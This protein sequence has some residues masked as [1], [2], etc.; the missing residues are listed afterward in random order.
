MHA[1]LGGTGGRLMTEDHE[2]EQ[3]ATL[4]DQSLQ[5]ARISVRTSDAAMGDAQRAIAKLV[6]F[7]LPRSPAPAS[8]GD[9]RIPSANGRGLHDEQVQPH[10][11]PS[12]ACDPTQVEVAEA[13]YRYFK[14]V[15]DATWPALNDE[16]RRTLAGTI[17]SELKQLVAAFEQYCETGPD[18]MAGLSCDSCPKKENCNTP[19][20][21]VKAYLGSPCAGKHHR[22]KTGGVHFDEIRARR[23]SP[24]GQDGDEKARRDDR[25]T[26]R[27]ITPVEPLDALESYTPCWDRLSHKQRK[28]VQLYYGEGERIKD[29]AR[30]LGR[31]SSTVHGL[32][33]RARETKDKHNERMKRQE[34]NLHHE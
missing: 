32:L 7:Y 15:L 33:S 13:A 5:K 12:Q 24:E 2:L 9:V 4:A 8:G 29:V 34:L 16:G 1:A 26:F 3:L 23:G 10:G 25:G 27:D 11:S 14:R 21:R 22:E 19:C 28:A 31:S 20:E 30:I 17:G 18:V 6:A